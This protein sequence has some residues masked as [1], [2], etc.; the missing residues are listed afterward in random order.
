MKS[1]RRDEVAQIRVNADKRDD[2]YEISLRAFLR[3]WLRP[4]CSFHSL[5][6]SM[7]MLSHWRTSCRLPNQRFFPTVIRGPSSG[8]SGV[9]R[10][11]VARIRSGLDAYL[12][13][14]P[15][16]H[17]QGLS[18]AL[19]TCEID[20]ANLRNRHC[21]PAKST[22]RRLQNRGCSVWTRTLKIM[23]GKISFP[24]R[25]LGLCRRRV[26][27]RRQFVANSYGSSPMRRLDNRSSG[28]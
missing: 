2:P 23:A 16:A 19:R 24:A 14:A 17:S 4:R 3:C 7:G 6:Y 12:V 27:I 25:V 15:A 10:D 18:G 9:S 13:F 26:S 11:D 5:V 20:T 28:P 1:E 21:E 22:A 8:I